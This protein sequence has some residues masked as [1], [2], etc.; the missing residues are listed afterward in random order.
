MAASGPVARTLYALEGAGLWA[1]YGLFGLL[2]VTWASAL[3]GALGRTFGPLTRSHARAAR[4]MAAALPD[5]PPAARRAALRDMWDNLARVVAEYPHLPAIVRGRVTLT[6]APEARA[7]MDAGGGGLFVSGHLANWEVLVPFF[8]AHTGADMALT[9]REPNNPWVAALLARARARAG[10]RLALAKRDRRTGPRLVHTLRRGGYAGILIDQ[11]YSE[12]LPVPLFGRPAMT[13]PVAVRLAR[14]FAVPLA[15]VRIERLPGA[16][17]AITLPP[18]VEVAG[19]TDAEVLADMHTTLEGWIRERPGQWLWLHRR[20][21]R[22][23]ED[24]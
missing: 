17:F 5:L 14:K 15:L 21:G 11:R 6:V 22:V 2:P 4:Q 18:P 10:V 3:A 7:L 13:N 12:G 9:F 19:R 24:K 1:L 16:R 20:W 23:F 8:I